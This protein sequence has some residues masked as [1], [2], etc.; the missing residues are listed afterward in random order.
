METLKYEEVFRSEYRDLQEAHL[1]LRE[2][3]EKIYNERRLHSALGMC[4]QRSSKP[5]SRHNKGRPLRGVFLH[6]FSQASGNLP[7]R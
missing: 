2:F 7:I 4:R 3:L 1:S 6:E 5:I